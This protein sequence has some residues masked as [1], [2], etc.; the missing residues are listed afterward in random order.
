MVRAVVDAACDVVPGAD[1]A[2]ATVR[3]SDGAFLGAAATDEAGAELDRVQ[4]GACDG[5]LLEADGGP[6]VLAGDLRTETRWSEFTSAA[7]RH[8]VRAVLA[9]GFLRADP[10]EPGGALVL[11]SR[12]A[13]GLTED[14]RD[15]ALLLVTHGSLALARCRAAEQADL[16]RINMKRAIESRD[17]IGQAKGILMKREGISAAAAF[18]LLRRTSQDR[19]VKVADLARTIIAR[20][21]DLG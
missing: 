14:D 9:T 21:D 18:E 19:N 16:L 2:G 10:A 17:L 4:Y 13:G 6:P 12:T 8:G 15:A 20:H 1:L 5:P 3:G 7:A 11:Y